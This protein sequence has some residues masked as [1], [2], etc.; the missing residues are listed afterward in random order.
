M[1][2]RKPMTWIIYISCVENIK[3]FVQGC[4]RENNNNF[5]TKST[6]SHKK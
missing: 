6:K 5:N 4:W 3:I 2:F 1:F